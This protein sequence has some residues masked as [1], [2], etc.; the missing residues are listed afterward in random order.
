MQVVCRSAKNK[1]QCG[2]ATIIS[3]LGRESKQDMFASNNHAK[4]CLIAQ[5][6]D[7]AVLFVGPAINSKTASEAALQELND[8]LLTRSYLVGQNL[9]LADVV[10]FY[11]VYSIMVI[12]FFFFKSLESFKFLCDFAEQLIVSRQRE[13]RKCLPLVR[14]FAEEQ[15]HSTELINSEFVEFTAPWM[16][17]RNAHLKVRGNR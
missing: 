17:L 10:L 13:I 12:V 9:S 11:S 1:N 8:Y 16:G 3:A 15:F 4:Q 5:W 6:F 7:Y 14:P 2:Y